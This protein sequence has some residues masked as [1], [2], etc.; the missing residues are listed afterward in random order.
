MSDT[1]ARLAALD[2][3]VS[4]LLAE[5]DRTQ[6]NSGAILDRWEFQALSPEAQQAAARARNL[7]AVNE[8]CHLPE[9]G[10][11]AVRRLATTPPLWEL[12][13]E[14]GTARLTSTQVAE[15][16]Y[17]KVKIA[18]ATGRVP[19]LAGGKWSLVWSALLGAAEDVDMGEVG[20]ERGQV[21]EWLSSYLGM[22]SLEE[23]VEEAIS[24]RNPYRDGSDVCVFSTDLL[25]HLRTMHHE[26]IDAKQ[27]AVMMR[28]AGVHPEQKGVHR[29]ERKTSTTIYRLG[30]ELHEYDCPDE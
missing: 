10:I 29:G 14:R 26:R 19:D 11:T 18:D 2:R 22:R 1:A 8:W 21:R 28:S 4:D 6:E 7:R 9:P 30:P 25:T 27:L 17:A 20:T 15:W 24:E 23:S 5:C 13:G 3:N 16:R 12:V